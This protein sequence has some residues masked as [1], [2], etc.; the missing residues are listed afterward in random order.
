MA[1]RLNTNPK[2]H[3]LILQPARMTLASMY[4]GT[5]SDPGTGKGPAMG[6]QQW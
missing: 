5:I 1:A 6:R 2:G 4:T 3:L